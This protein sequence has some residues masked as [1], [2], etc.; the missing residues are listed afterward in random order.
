MSLRSEKTCPFSGG[1]GFGGILVGF[2]RVYC[3]F[4]G[5]VFVSV[6]CGVKKKGV[7]WFVVQFF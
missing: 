1:G 3:V 6:G 2:Q 5:G 7:G 4:A